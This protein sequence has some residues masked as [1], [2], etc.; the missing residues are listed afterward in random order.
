MP[1][2]PGWTAGSANTH[3]SLSDFCLGFGES[4]QV[5]HEILH[6]HLRSG[7]N[8]F[9]THC[10]P[11]SASVTDCSS[12]GEPLSPA[13][14]PVSRHPH[15]LPVLAPLQALPGLVKS[16][17]WQQD[18]GEMVPWLA[19]LSPKATLLT[20]ATAPSPHSRRAQICFPTFPPLSKRA[21]AVVCSQGTATHLEQ[22]LSGCSRA[23]PAS[24]EEGEEAPGLVLLGFTL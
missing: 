12:R 1:E 22:L 10:I 15:L 23:H 5:M 14:F 7:M 9:L 16:R 8:S 24:E 21:L 17:N 2:F 4:P 3:C 11:C 6:S 18:T 13:S 19:S 20:L